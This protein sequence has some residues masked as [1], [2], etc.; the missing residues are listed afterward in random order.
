MK[1]WKTLAREATP[2]GAELLL[3]ERDG[4]YLIRV[5]GVELMSSAR[6]GSEEA[7]AALALSAVGKHARVLVGGLG[8]GYTLRATLDRLSADAKVVVAEIS[9]VVVGWNRG[10]LGPLAGSPLSDPRVRV[11]V[12]DVGAILAASEALDAV[13]LDVD[14]GPSA[15]FREGN[16][17]LYSQDGLVAA[18]RA[19]VPGGVLAVWSAGPEAGFTAALRRAGFDAQ[20]H[21]TP[22]RVGSPTR[23]TVFLARRR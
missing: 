19:L 9:P 16:R 18:R 15:L 5:G 17:G 12:G 7:L 8:L 21:T 23:H 3:Q 4:T 10:P 2:E 13:L 22:A 20:E 1:P 14:N 6:H 11:E